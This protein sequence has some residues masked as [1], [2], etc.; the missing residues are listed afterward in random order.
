MESR[1]LYGAA[2]PPDRIH[3]GK[4]IAWNMCRHPRPP[5][6]PLPPDPCPRPIPIPM[7]LP[8]AGFADPGIPNPAQVPAAR[9]LIAPFPNG[10]VPSPLG[11]IVSSFFKILLLFP[12]HRVPALRAF[13]MNAGR[14]AIMRFAVPAFRT[15]AGAASPPR[16]GTAHA[17][18]ALSG[19]TLTP[20]SARPRSVLLSSV[21]RMFLLFPDVRPRRRPSPHRRCSADWRPIAF[22][23]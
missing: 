7:P 16:K 1:F 15:Q 23:C 2:N 22:R 12:G 9:P 19:A 18:S 8:R 5:P 14:S 11:M 6:P 3:P 17:T 4:P 13:P 21:H 10:P 20:S